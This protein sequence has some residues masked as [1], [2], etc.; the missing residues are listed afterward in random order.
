MVLCLRDQVVCKSHLNIM[1][2]NRAGLAK[3]IGKTKDK[4]KGEMRYRPC[5]L[6]G[7]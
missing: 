7:V 6:L 5:W 3:G 2:S 4:R 1:V